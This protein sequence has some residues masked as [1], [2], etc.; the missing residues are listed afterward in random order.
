MKEK[1]KLDELKVRSFVTALE[2][3]HTNT[4]K[5][6][7]WGVTVRLATLAETLHEVGDNQSWWHCGGGAD[8]GFD[9][10]VDSQANCDHT[11]A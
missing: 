9:I 4:A 3:S 1:L 8:P 7:T 11:Q 5:G 2:D 10:T 6:G